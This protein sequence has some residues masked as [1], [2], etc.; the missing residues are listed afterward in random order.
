MQQTITINGKRY[1]AHQISKLMSQ[2]NMTRGDD[3]IIMLNGR[4]Y[5]ANY[6]QIQDANYAPTCD[7]ARAN[8][9]ALMFDDGLFHWD[10]WLDYNP[11]RSLAAATLGS[12]RTPRKAASSATNGKLGGRPRKIKDNPNEEK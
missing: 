1:T 12:I 10:I 6:R 2:D 7:K 4:K 8:A 3:Y 5:F 11:V 9:I